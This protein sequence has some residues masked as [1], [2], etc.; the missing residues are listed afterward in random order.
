MSM[1]NNNPEEM[2]NVFIDIFDDMAEV[3]TIL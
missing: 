1:G 2:R 3:F